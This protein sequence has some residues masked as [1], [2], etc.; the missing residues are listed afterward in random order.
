MSIILFDKWKIE[1]RNPLN[2]ELSEKS[3]T[4]K[5][6]VVSEAWTFR[7]YFRDF[8]NVAIRISKEYI[9]NTCDEADDLRSIIK[10]LPSIENRLKNIIVEKLEEV[11]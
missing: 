8:D 9:N 2:L 7:G 11:E 5:D 10:A 4:E 3:I 1:R 6:G